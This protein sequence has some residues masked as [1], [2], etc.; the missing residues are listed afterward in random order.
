[1]ADHEDPRDAPEGDGAGSRGARRGLVRPLLGLASLLPL[2]A[3]VGA[4]AMSP[5]AEPSTVLRA[6]TQAQPG[7]SSRWCPGPLQVPEA[8]LD[9]NGDAELSVA[10]P[11]SSVDLGSIAFE[12]D[13]SVLFGTVSGSGTLQQEDGTVRAPVL[14]TQNLEG[15]SIEEETASAELGLGMQPVAGIQGA[16]VVRATTAEGERPITDSIQSTST[17][18][19]DFRSLALTRCTEPTTDA[20]FLGVSTATG[21]SS[22]LVLRNPTQR[23]ATASVEVWTEE[24]PAAMEG[25]SQ[26]IVGPGEEERVLLESVAGGHEAV[27]VRA[28]VLG[29]PLSMHIQTTERDGLTPGGAEILEPLPAAASEQVM[30]GVEVAGTTPMLVLANP[31]GG[32]TTAAVDVL[33][34]DGAIAEAGLEEVEVPSGGV[35]RVPLEGLEDGTYT[36]RVR[37]Q[38]AVLATTR[39][40]ATGADLEGDTLGAPVD[41]SLVSSA[42]T[43]GTSGVIALPA[44]GGAGNL[45]LTSEV[46]GGVSIVP[47]AADGSA[48]EPVGVELS[49]GA[50]VT[51]TAASLEVG[52][53]PPSGLTVVPEV[54]GAVR[55]A[56]MQRESDGAGG[57]L[58][59]SL[60]VASTQH[61]GESH[62]VRLQD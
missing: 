8:L 57:V 61:S 45:T 23:P 56:W 50:S 6:E 54:P 27:G 59:S 32:G 25:R 36:V 35:V 9:E 20:S 34:A 52:G 24:G 1:M 22:V 49:E 19:G 51:V 15:E 29:A 47:L 53:A 39:S 28:S 30:P 58:L 42:P 31:R 60:P 33:G 43:L 18:S 44:R 48:G 5:A 40:S 21:D 11:T 55:A 3:A 14:A 41:F 16:P 38:D 13:S 7:A 17:T 12:P 46:A 4:L 37:A 62:T 26:V 10:P 2:V